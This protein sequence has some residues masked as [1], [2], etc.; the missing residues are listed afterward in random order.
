M[1]D[2]AAAKIVS[3]LAI[4]QRGMTTH[5]L[6]IEVGCSR[7]TFHRAIDFLRERGIMLDYSR[8]TCRWQL[9]HPDD[10]GGDPRVSDLCAAGLIDADL[11]SLLAACHGAFRRAIGLA[12][13]D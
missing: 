2:E 8:T 7:P 11:A 1:R 10:A 9:A 3:L 13:N 5:T 4:S 12:A 6:L